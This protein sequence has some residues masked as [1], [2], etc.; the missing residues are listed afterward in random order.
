MNGL[1][2]RGTALEN[3]WAREQD[4]IALR[5]LREKTGTDATKTATDTKD[6]K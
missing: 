5:N 1:K 4:A 6:K 3:A 2:D